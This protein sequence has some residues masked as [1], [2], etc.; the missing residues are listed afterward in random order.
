VLCIEDNQLNLQL[1]EAMLAPCPGLTLFT[2][3]DP[4]TGLHLARASHPDLI[5]L[6]I[7]LP[8]M[9]GHEVIARLKA[10]PQTADIPVVAVTAQAMPEDLKRAQRSGF[11]A[12]IT[13]PIDADVLLAEVERWRPGQAYD[14]GPG[15]ALASPSPGLPSEPS[16]IGE[17]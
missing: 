11:A 17:H 13:K 12:Y 6:D 5:L 16:P 15:T 2:A 14:P 9:D 3:A 10:D 1:I 4:A 7:H 8:E